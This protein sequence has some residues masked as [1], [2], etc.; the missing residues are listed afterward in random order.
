MRKISD[1]VCSPCRVENPKQ[2]QFTEKPYHGIEIP[3]IDS[4]MG[5]DN[6]QDETITT[7]S[8]VCKNAKVDRSVMK[9]VNNEQTCGNDHNLPTYRKYI[10][11]IQYRARRKSSLVTTNWGKIL[12]RKNRFAVNDSVAKYLTLAK[13]LINWASNSLCGCYVLSLC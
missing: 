3:G 2:I 8:N 1:S 4:K 12:T 6:T 10:E 9:K 13:V 11:S 7:H 5:V